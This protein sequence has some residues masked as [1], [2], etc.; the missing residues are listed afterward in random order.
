MMSEIQQYCYACESC[1]KSKTSPHMKKAPLSPDTIPSRPFE[2][3]A[4][5]ILGPL[6]ETY[7]GNKYVLVVTCAFSRYPEAIALPDQQSPTVAKA[8]VEQVICRHG[9]PKEVMSDRGT[10]FCSAL[11]QQVNEILK[12]KRKLT[13]AYHLMAN[14]GAENLVKNLKNMLIHYVNY[15]HN[16]W[17]SMIPFVL[18][19]YR[20][21]INSSTLETPFYLLHGRDPEL[22]LNNNN[23]NKINK[24]FI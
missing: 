5:D 9:M 22:P 24:T 8:F 19:A 15:Y 17:D 11:F 2:R 20:N 13:S 14:G 4:I 16:D 7:H 10:N 6:K 18:F 1:A 3:V 12:I 23:N 21:S